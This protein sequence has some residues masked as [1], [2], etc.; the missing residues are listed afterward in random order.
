MVSQLASPISPALWG[1]KT[2]QWDGEDIT[3]FDV[4][5]KICP[6]CHQPY[7]NA[8]AVELASEFVSFVEGKY[9]RDLLKHIT[10]LDRKLMAFVD[11][12]DRLQPKQKE[13]AKQI[14]NKILPIIERILH[15]TTLV[16]SLFQRE[17]MKVQK[18]QWGILRK[19]E[20]FAKQQTLPRQSWLQKTILLQQSLG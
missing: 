1:M 5:W 3:A 10:A 7:Q 20:I 16:L 13:E 4:P 9:P 11:I 6:S 14:A 12:R 18:L 17:Q 2:E 19:C 8:F 15:T